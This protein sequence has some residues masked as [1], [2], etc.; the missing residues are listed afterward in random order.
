M[1]K[2]ITPLFIEHFPHSLE[3][4][5]LYVSLE[6]NTAVH[7][8]ACGCKSETITKI[9]PKEW[10]LEYDGKDISLFPSIGNW[11][12]PC[13]SHYWIREGKIILIDDSKKSKS[14][15]KK[16]EKKLMPSIKKFINNKIL[17]T[18]EKKHSRS[19]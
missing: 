14:K 13:R 12:Y 19:I 11:D 16:R 3:E 1:N 2:S 17:K 10:S 7:L 4:G 8:C 6:F 5:V 9:A 15:S 18:N